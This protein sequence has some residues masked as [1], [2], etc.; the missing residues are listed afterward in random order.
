MRATQPNEKYL[1]YDIMDYIGAL[2]AVAFADI[3]VNGKTWGFLICCREPRDSYVQSDLRRRSWL[4]FTNRELG[5]LGKGQDERFI[6]GHQNAEQAQTNRKWRSRS[7][8]L[9]G[10]Q[11]KSAKRRRRFRRQFDVGAEWLQWRIM[12]YIDDNS[13]S[14]SAMFDNSVFDTTENDYNV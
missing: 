10:K 1:S 3:S 4:S 11:S 13:S 2:S 12:Q 9:G 14:Y 6:K 8:K 7:G 5:M